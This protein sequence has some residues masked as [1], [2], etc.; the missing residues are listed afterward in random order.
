MSLREIIPQGFT[1]LLNLFGISLQSQ[2][3]N[4][5]EL[6]GTVIPVALVAST[7]EIQAV[8]T[9]MTLDVP[10]TAG[11]LVA[12]VAGTILADT[13][14]LAGGT[15]AVT[16]MVGAR[17]TPGTSIDYYLQ[18]RNAANAANIWQQ[19]GFLWTSAPGLQVH[20][21]VAR[22]DPLERLRALAITNGTLTA[23]VSI[24]TQRLGD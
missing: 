16:V 24:W 8:S 10:A 1:D 5:F 4:T 18:R 21:F 20:Q 12:P 6:Q 11:E 2:K 23:Q 14:Q 7:T 17:V 15:Y 19:S 3:D 22:F 9:P 13:G